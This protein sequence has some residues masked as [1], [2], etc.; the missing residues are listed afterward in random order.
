MGTSKRRAAPQG[1]STRA[2]VRSRRHRASRRRS[3]TAAAT[4]RS[5]RGRRNERR[6]T[7]M[8]L[9]VHP[10][11]LSF[12]AQPGHG[13]IDAVRQLFVG[14]LVIVAHRVLQP[15]QLRLQRRGDLFLSWGA[16]KTVQLPR[17]VDQVEQ[18]PLILLPEVN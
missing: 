2:A 4:W 17:V 16:V 14:E 5:A 6:R 15:E 12:S 9:P 3:T 18:L 11:S 13:S 7:L 10:S 8:L 1:G